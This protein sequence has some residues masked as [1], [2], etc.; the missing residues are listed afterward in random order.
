MEIEDIIFSKCSGQEADYLFEQWR[1]IVQNNEQ[2]SHKRWLSKEKWLQA[3]E[4]EFL[5]T[6]ANSNPI[7]LKGKEKPTYAEAINSKQK[8]YHHHHHQNRQ[9]NEYVK[10]V[11]HN[12]RT[13]TPNE[14]EIHTVSEDIINIQMRT[15]NKKEG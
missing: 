3:Y 10:N 8:Q 5:K 6:Y 15:D 12:Q 13:Y 4:E 14:T 11:Q 9:V 7:F 2:I 1:M